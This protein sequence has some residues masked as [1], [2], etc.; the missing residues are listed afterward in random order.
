MIGTYKCECFGGMYY[1]DHCEF[2]TRKII[3]IKFV[4][5]SFAYVGILAMVSVAIFI[6]VMDILKY[7]F[8]IDPVHEEREKL[9]HEKRMKQRRVWT[10]R[11]IYVNQPTK[12]GRPIKIMKKQN[13]S[14][15]M[16]RATVPL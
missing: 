15:H 9:R 8:G 13:I 1:G 11:Y 7:G 5:K 10:Y 14:S 4:A 6:I 3:I 12:F 2:T 16:K